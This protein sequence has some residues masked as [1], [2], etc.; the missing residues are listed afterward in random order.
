VGH[1]TFPKSTAGAYDLFDKVGTFSE[2]L[3]KTDPTMRKR[4]VPF[5]KQYIEVS[6][7][8]MV[9]VEGELTLK[10]KER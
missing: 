7:E 6:E 9:E 2:V 4:L 3:S 8:E 10:H 1:E 5:P